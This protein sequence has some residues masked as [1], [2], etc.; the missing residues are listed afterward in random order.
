MK[1]SGKISGLYAIIDTALVKPGRIGETARKILSGGAGIIQLRSKDSGD[2]GDLSSKEFLDAAKTLKKLT[3]K[4]NAV[5][6]VNDRVDIALISGADGVHL[7]QK[8]LP[9]RIARKLLGKNKMVGLSTHT[10]AEAS[11]AGKLASKGLVDYI[12]FGPVF[13]TKTKKN[14]RKAVGTAKLK[15]VKKSVNLPVVAI[16]GIKEE[17]IPEVLKTGVDSVAMISGILEA[18]DIQSKISSISAAIK[19]LKS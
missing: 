17:N 18:K 4:Y 13:S 7:G 8:D 2:S 16:G 11:R 3:V 5:F 15:K 1:K 9:P 14:A 19:S 12:S 6:I 10:T